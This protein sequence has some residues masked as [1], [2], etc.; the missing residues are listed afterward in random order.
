MIVT[1]ETF[2]ENLVLL[3]QYFD[4]VKLSEWVE[5]KAQDLPLPPKACAVT[6]DDGWADN[7]EFAFPILRELEIPATIFLVSDMIGT[8]DMFWPERLARTVTAIAMEHPQQ[9]SNTNLAWLRTNA[10]SYRFSNIPPTPEQISQLIAHA[11]DLPDEEIHRRLDAIEAELGLDCSSDSAALLSWEQ[12]AEMTE[13]GLVEVGSHTCRHTRLTAQTPKDA[14]EDE[15]LTSKTTIEKHT[16]HPVKTFCF[17]NGDY[18]Q[19][20][21]HLVRET[22]AGAVTTQSGWNTARTD[23]HLLHRIGIHEDIANDKT[24]F[25]A[26]ISG[27]L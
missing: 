23:N 19:E 21:L 5:R 3:T 25:L 7:Y 17:P 24:A 8:R 15:I 16:G 26:R 12:V 9:C 6:F 20:A 10:T 27:W 2:R 11:K 22:Y 4:I 1:P 13:S 18:S 14:L